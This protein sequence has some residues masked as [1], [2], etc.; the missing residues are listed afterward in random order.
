[1]R[2]GVRVSDQRFLACIIHR[3]YVNPL[4]GDEGDAF[5][6]HFYDLSAKTAHTMYHFR[7]ANNIREAAQGPQQESTPMET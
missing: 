6:L 7:W 4:S 2:S 3:F 5:V 1:V